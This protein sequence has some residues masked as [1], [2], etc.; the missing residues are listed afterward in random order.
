DPRSFRVVRNCAERPPEPALLEQ[1]GRPER[2][3]QRQPD[4][5]EGP[6]LDLRA[7]DPDKP[8]VADAMERQRVREDVAGALEGRADRGPDREGDGRGP[9]DPADRRPAREVRLNEPEVGEDPGRDAEYEAH[10][11]SPE[12]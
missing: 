7:P 1:P 10:D 8:R 9:G 5:E 4:H 3:G 2:E 12:E 11:E 6:R